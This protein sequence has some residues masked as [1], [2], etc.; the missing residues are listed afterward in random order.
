[1][2]SFPYIKNLPICD[3]YLKI[4]PLNKFLTA[5]ICICF[6]A[7]F[8]AFPV[9]VFT[10]TLPFCSSYVISGLKEDD[11]SLCCS[12]PKLSRTLVIACLKKIP[13]VGS[14]CLSGETGM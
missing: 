13:E 4:M 2:F 7:Y 1:M 12:D 8:F 5:L 3:P 11:P 6:V 14:L 10:V 9:S